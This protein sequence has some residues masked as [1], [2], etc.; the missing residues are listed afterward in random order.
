MNTDPIADFLKKPK[1]KVCLVLAE[2]D[3]QTNLNKI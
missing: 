2:E 3:T 1:E